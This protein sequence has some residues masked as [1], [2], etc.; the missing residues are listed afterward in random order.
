MKLPPYSPYPGVLG[1]KISL[2]QISPSDIEDII[3]IS[4]Y[5]SLQASNL[6]EAIEMNSKIIKDYEQGNSIHWGIAENTSNT[7]LGT[8]GYY[9]GFAQERGELG[10]VLLPQYRGQGFMT[11][12]LQLAID[13]GIGHIGLKRIWAVTSTENYKAGKL[14]DRL[15]FIQI[16]DLSNGEIEYAL[17]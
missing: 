2:R 6:K 5:D 7:I 9:R 14:L 13:F 10:C 8:C 16:K 11:A 15:G 4:Y 17:K 1:E 12:A 3:E